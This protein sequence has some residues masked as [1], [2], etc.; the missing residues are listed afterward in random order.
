MS[1]RDRT[2]ENLTAELV[3]IRH[4]MAR[5]EA[6]HRLDE[7]R[8]KA[9]LDLNQM[10][11]LPL[12]EV[13]E[14][15]LEEAVRLTESRIGYL[16][17]MNEDETVLTMQVWSKTAMEGCAVE[18]QPMVFPLETTG[19]WGEAVRQRRPVIT[20]E[21]SAADPLFKGTPEGHVEIIRHMNVPVFDE[22][23]IVLVAGVGNKTEGYDESDV[24]QLTL[25]MDGMWKLLLRRRSEE[26]LREY[27][28]RM[29]DL[30]EEALRTS[31]LKY[32]MLYDS[33]RD[34]IML[35][36][37]ERGFIGGN[38][39]AIRLFGC[40]SEVEFTS[41]SP[42][43]LSPEHQ[44]DGSRSGEAAQR[45]MAMAMERGSHFFEWKHRRIDGVEFFATVLL[46]RMELEGEVLLQATVRDITLEKMVAR[47]LEDA[48]NAAEAASRAK[49]DF[50]ANMS[51]EIRTPMN[52]IVG[53]TELL[54][55]TELT[56]TQRD[57]LN[58]VGESADSLLLLIDDIL[59]LSRI[60]AGKLE[61]EC[62][63]FDLRESLGDTMKLLAVRAHS[64]GLELAC[65]IR[66]DV[67]E[68]LLGDV[69]RLRQVVVNLIGNGIK[70]TESG[71]VALEVGV[72]IWSGNSTLVH[73]AITDTGIG[74][75]EEI[76]AAIFGAFEQG[77]Q[78]TTRRFGGTG[79]GLAISS[80]LVEM[81]GGRIWMES[82]VGRGSAF[83]FTA[84]FEL[85]RQEIDPARA[86]VRPKV[87]GIPVLVVDDNATNRRF[88]GDTLSSWKM[89]SKPVDGAGAALE[90]LQRAN[91]AGDP[92][93]LVL[94]DAD[95][96]GTSGFEL[97]E[98][99]NRNPK[100]DGAI[101][102]MLT[103]GGRPDDIARCERLGISWYLLKPVKQ[104]EL[105]DAVVMALGIWTPEDNGRSDAAGESAPRLRALE[106]LLAEDSLV[107]QKVAVGLLTKYGH[108]VHVV[109]D[110]TEAIK[111]L[112]TREF[113]LVLMD[114]QMPE[115]DGFEATGIIRARER[116]TGR[117]IPII[118]LTAHA[119]K[120]DRDQCLKAGMDDYVAKPI[121]S[122]QLL[123]TMRTV[124]GPGAEVG[125]RVA[126]RWAQDQAG[127]EGQVGIDWSFALDALNDDPGL[128]R[129]VVRAALKEAP[130]LMGHI[131]L[132]ITDGDA[133][134][135]RIAA[136]TL[137]G[138]VRYFGEGRVY[139]GA[140]QMEQWGGEERVDFA[141]QALVDLE[142]EVQKLVL[143]L[144]EFLERGGSSARED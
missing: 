53:M 34:A 6:S 81:M 94:T 44:P 123:E 90:M 54:L 70:F 140:Y 45:M 40:G 82:V 88:L 136:H 67:P 5:A 100:L 73:F 139:D 134:G 37:M 69:G 137:K 102:M 46:T 141:L 4:R 143:G 76:Q 9:L 21:Y 79:L 31:E 131:R 2:R 80:R 87:T 96:P 19:L 116:D 119:L 25:L 28:T 57:Y 118:A 55:G 135:L 16:A 33:S 29:G 77:D 142:N 56:D 92:F 35:T 97:A 112:D 1:D 108:R 75:G 62:E 83:H 115:M 122:R 66:S 132:A 36:T 50:L 68:C 109:N 59:D 129:A 41:C 22:G 10:V 8:F 89:R 39:A 91:D 103:S 117:H 12:R 17:F 114:V 32:R 144:T 71:E 93:K 3:E 86:V 30:V 51:H 124:L 64:K 72:Q 78:S 63:P 48:K 52:A 42:A 120:G 58:V 15:A 7:S 133:P 106:I 127:P 43:D 126:D 125:K 104:S 26:E 107:N 121:H 113:D 60:E 61:L 24:R 101:I 27:R 110:G 18:E 130:R 95:M 14:F 47:D 105:F 128:L 38:P 20:N 84:E 23:R 85:G 13:M 111:A 65:K 74:I 49:S 98:E 138:A 11:D 99:I